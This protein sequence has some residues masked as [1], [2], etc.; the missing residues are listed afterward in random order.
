MLAMSRQNVLLVDAD[1][2]WQ[3]LTRTFELEGQPGLADVCLNRCS[4]NDV[5]LPTTVAGFE[6]LPAGT[7]RVGGE[8]LSESTGRLLALLD[9]WKGHFDLVL[10]DGGDLQSGLAAVVARMC[11]A[12]YVVVRL[13]RTPRRLAMKALQR[14]KA[15]GL[16]PR[17]CI[18]TNANAMTVFPEA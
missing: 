4:W 8:S 16:A 17:G 6:L 5:I 14:L 13:G 9:A 2:L 11:Q 3:R 12:V 7:G 10:V 1:T 18:A 15:E